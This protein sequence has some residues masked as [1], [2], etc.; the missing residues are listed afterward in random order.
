M[1]VL[2]RFFSMSLNAISPTLN[3]NG[4]QVATV[5]AGCFWGV[6]H[7]YRKHFGNG[8]GLI[9][10]RVGYIGGK[11]SSPTYKDVCSDTTGHAE[12]FQFTFDPKIVTYETLIDFF[13]RMHDPTT[14]NKQG[15]DTGSQYRSEI[16]TH[17]DEQQKT[18]EQVKERMQETFYPKNRIVTRIQ[19]AGHFWDAETYHQLYL[20]KNPGG[21]ECP[22]HFLRTTPQL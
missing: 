6:E 3:V 4:F 17:S 9:D 1:P 20:H 13:F 12:A 10:G 14:V 16:F 11:S 21:Y 18:A 2:E 8:R 5:C 15:P 19:P 22:S 7:M